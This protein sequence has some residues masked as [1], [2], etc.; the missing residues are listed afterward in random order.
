MLVSYRSLA[1][2]ATVATILIAAS[3]ATAARAQTTAQTME[4]WGLLGTWAVDCSQPPSARNSYT[5]YVATSGGEVLQVRHLG[6]RQD[7]RR[8]QAAA[9][10]RDGMIEVVTDFSDL[11]WGMHK[12]TFQ[13]GTDGRIKAMRSGKLDGT[14]DTIR[15]GKFVRDG[16]P[17]RWQ[18]R[19]SQRLETA[20]AG[21]FAQR[22]GT[23]A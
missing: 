1:R 7:S 18:S 13:K 2:V 8:I 23:P 10:R 6:R 22:P 9:V 17:A 20:G 12:T 11:G 16:R 19:C 14:Q 3:H 4:E 21:R 15:S 5:S